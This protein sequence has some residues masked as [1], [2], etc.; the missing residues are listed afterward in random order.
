MKETVARLDNYL[1]EELGKSLEQAWT[2]K[3]PRSP[4]SESTTF[5]TVEDAYRVQEAWT[6][7]RLTAGD[8]L[9]GRKI[10]LTSEAVQRQLGVSEPDF[11]NLWKS[12][13]FD[14]NT[15]EV[16]VPAALFLQPR[17]EGELAFKL[18]KTLQGPGLTLEDVLGATEALAYAIEIVDSR[19]ANWN[20]KLVD[21]VADNASFGGFCHGAWQRDLLSLDLSTLTM[22]LQKNGADAVQGVG[23]ACLKN[24]AL[25]VAWL[26]NTLSHFEVTLNPGDIV[27]SG[28]WM[29]VVPAGQGDV[30]RLEGAGG[31][32]FTLRFV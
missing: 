32:P 10:G 23:V 12:R 8:E 7:L 13:Y 14:A 5:S 27:M 20:I 9:V 22:T 29:P 6:K 4:I 2:N 1:I 19:I 11:G 28:A 18:G 17:V 15:G 16:S 21:T 31:V 3:T 25:A 30:F 24:P 26:A